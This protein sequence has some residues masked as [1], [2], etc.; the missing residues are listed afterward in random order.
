MHGKELETFITPGKSMDISHK[1]AGMCS[2]ERDFLAIDDTKNTIGIYKS[3]MLELWTNLTS[4]RD[5]N[6]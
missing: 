6:Q 2:L 3:D 1:C 4:Q 5:S